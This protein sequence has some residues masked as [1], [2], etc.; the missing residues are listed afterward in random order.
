MITK[1]KYLSDGIG[2][3]FS[4][5]IHNNNQ[6]QGFSGNF[7]RNYIFSGNSTL[8]KRIDRKA[9]SLRKCQ[10]ISRNFDHALFHFCYLQDIFVHIF[11]DFF[12]FLV[13]IQVDPFGAP[14]LALPAPPGPKS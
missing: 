12:T 7:A 5:G 11:N 13:F 3:A 6:R 4:A 9:H 2:S 1:K 10:T 8:D 14:A